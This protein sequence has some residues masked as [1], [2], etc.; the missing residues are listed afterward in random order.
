MCDT[1][2]D[3]AI[4]TLLETLDFKNY[5]PWRNVVREKITCTADICAKLD[6]RDENHCDPIFRK[7]TA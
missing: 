3:G 5:Q 4:R 1:M 2:L 7:L 6:F